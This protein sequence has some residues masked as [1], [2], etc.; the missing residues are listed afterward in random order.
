MTFLLSSQN[1]LEYLRG[2]GICTLEDRISKI[3]HKSSKNFNLVVIFSDGRYLLVKQ[4]RLNKEGKT[5]NDF[6]DDWCIYQLF[7]KFP[8]LDSLRLLVCEAIHFDL[9]RSII[10][11]NYLNDHCDLDSFYTEKR[12]FPSAIASAIGTNLATI[13]RTTIDSGQYKTFLN[14][15]SEKPNVDRVP[16]FLRGLEP[17][18]PEIFG[19]VTADGIQF[20][21]LYQLYESLGKAI[22][23]LNAAF[24]SC[25]LIHKDFKL[26]NVLVHNNWEQ[27]KSASPSS[28]VRLIDWEHSSWGDP[29]LD[30]GM[31]IASYLKIWLAS[32]V[33][34]TDMD[35]ATSLHSAITPLEVL[36][37]SI[38][39]LTVAYFQ[40]FPE[41]IQRR[42]DFLRRVTQFTGLSLLR[43]IQ[44]QLQYKESFNNQGICTLQ[45]AK[46]LLCD[47]E[48]SIPTVFGVEEVEL[49]K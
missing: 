46:T 36:Q 15:A 35:L 26:D 34:C 16:N 19:K 2:Q 29:A 12:I 32:L 24:H 23:Q 21:R 38:R 44:A 33:I 17:I 41:I 43:Q 10:V 31:A 48:A 28:I 49:L 30:L 39:A 37:P 3:E 6:L 20:F 47:P 27:A 18:E 40:H 13:H 7:Q 42:P 11:F 22:T 5:C 9:E 45:V 8:E 1:V 4:E 14:Q 25:C